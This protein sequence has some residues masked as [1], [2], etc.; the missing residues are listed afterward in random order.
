MKRV[1]IL[2]IA[3]LL[4]ATSALAAGGI[5]LSLDA[6]PPNGRWG[7]AILD[8]GSGQ[9][10]LIIGTW[11]PAEAIPDLVTLDGILDLSV[12]GGVASNSFW[13]LDP[14][15]CN[16]A[17]LSASGTRPPTGCSAPFVYTDAWSAI[18]IEAALVDPQTVRLAFTVSRPTPL[19][20]AAGEH[21]FGMELRIDGLAA[22]EA[23]GPCVG[24][25]NAAY[26]IWTSGKPGS[27]GAVQPTELTQGTAFLP[28]F[29]NQL[30]L[31]GCGLP[32]RNPTWGR[33]KTLYR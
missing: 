17:G 5:D 8:C 30:G 20:V 2:G 1:I 15:G 7:C 6:C 19:S 4:A 9:E 11:A 27:A 21:V 14:A 25:S 24:C 29:S 28:G 33:L 3:M 22:V 13:N 32:I 31:Q 23:G 18:A 12:S 16:G 10:L 26:L